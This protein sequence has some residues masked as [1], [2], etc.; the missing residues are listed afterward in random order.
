M[1]GPLNPSDRKHRFNKA[2]MHDHVTDPYVREAQ[3]RGYRSRAAFKLLEL[4][5][6]DH[7]LRPG[8]SV[9]DLAQHRRRQALIADRDYR[10]QVMRLRAELTASGGR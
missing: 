6:R 10:A 8:M 1:A 3:R 2:W 9:V 7:L 4:D 5:Q